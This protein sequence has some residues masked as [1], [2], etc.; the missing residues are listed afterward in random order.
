MRPGIV[1]V[2]GMGCRKYREIAMVATAPLNQTTKI[3]LDVC[4]VVRSS[5]SETPMCSG[6]A[7]NAYQTNAVNPAH[8][9]AELKSF[10]TRA[11]LT[12][13]LPASDTLASDPDVLSLAAPSTGSGQAWPDSGFY[14]RRRK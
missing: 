14:R 8:A 9:A 10:A 4:A 1:H 6:T 13:P 12:Y 5:C 3:Q 7:P 2:I 11:V